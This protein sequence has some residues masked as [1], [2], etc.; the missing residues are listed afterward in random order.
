MSYQ[1]PVAPLSIGGVLDSAIRLYRDCMRR[2]WILSLLYAVVMGLDRKS[3][4]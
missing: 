1:L 3:V 4:V 2:C